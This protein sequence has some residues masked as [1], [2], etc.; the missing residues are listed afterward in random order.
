MQR[1]FTARHSLQEDAPDAGARRWRP[2]MR[3]LMRT[4]DEAMRKNTA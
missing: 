3:T 1:E 2:E 4:L